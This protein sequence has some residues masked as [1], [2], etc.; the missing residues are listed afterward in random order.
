MAEWTQAA[1]QLPAARELP[2][3][4]LIDHMPELIDQLAEVSEHCLR[5]PTGDHEEAFETARVHALDRLKEG[6]DLVSVISEL[7]ILRGVILAVWQRENATAYGSE[8]R[9]LNLAID[10]AIIATARRFAE[11]RAT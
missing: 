7:S 5:A 4:T 11:A 2:S 1:R 10:E 8:F 6:F 9:A 3:L